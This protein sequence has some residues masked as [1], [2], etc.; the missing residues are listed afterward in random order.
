MKLIMLM[1][2]VV[3]INQVA[4][5]S[6]A[7]Q[8]RTGVILDPASQSVV[9]MLPEGGVS[10][11]DIQTGM[12]R[13][14]STE[15]DKPLLIQGNQLLSQQSVNKK[16]VLS[17]AY[18]SMN[19][20]QIQNQVAL[21]LPNDVMAHVVNTTGTEF[22]IAA[23]LASQ[24][25]QLEWSFKDKKI[26]G[27]A[28]SI[29]NFLTQGATN[30][31][32]A[33]EVQ[34]GLINIDF[35]STNAQAATDAVE[36]NSIKKSIETKVLNNVSGRQFLSQDGAH[37]LVSQRLPGNKAI[38]YQWKVFTASGKSV[39]TLKNNLSY[40]PF[41]VSGNLLIAVAPDSVE[42]NSNTF[43][44]HPPLLTAYNLESQKMV[45]QNPIRSIKYFGQ[46]PH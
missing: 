31:H 42:V 16:G 10:A 32:A 20:G 33:S 28:P 23:N 15:S 41:V 7:V 19:D 6:E 43:S 24:K 8:L 12:T 3:G 2:G 34:K 39:G 5:S 25:Q 13:W 18:Q 44:N 36:R 4:S 30:R 29:E 40:M 9:A 45:W 26:T 11:F 22:K 38:E 46:V 17:L 21:D 27:A 35:G 37:V 14:S 1:L